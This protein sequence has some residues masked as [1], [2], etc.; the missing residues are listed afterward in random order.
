MNEVLTSTV[1]QALIILI[2]IIITTIV[3]LIAAKL[4]TFLDSKT[5]KNYTEAIREY[6]QTLYDSMESVAH[7]ALSRVDDPNDPLIEGMVKDLLHTTFLKA[8][9]ELRTKTGVTRKFTIEEVNGI[10]NSSIESA[11]RIR[12]G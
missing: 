3:A 11:Y 5:V 8:S 12:Q 2:P 10:V 7:N 6:D 4:R 1:T 9:K